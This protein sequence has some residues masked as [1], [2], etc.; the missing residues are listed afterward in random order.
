[1]PA[2]ERDERGGHRPEAMEHAGRAVIFSGS[3]VA[4]SLLALVVLPVPFLRSLGFAGLL[5]P[6]VSVAVA[7]TLLPVVLATIGPRLDRLRQPARRTSAG[8]GWSAWARLH[9][10]APLVVARSVDRHPPRAVLRRLHDPA[11]QPACRAAF[12]GGTGAR[13]ARPAGRTPASEPAPL[14]RSTRSS[15]GRPGRRRP[16]RSPRSRASGV[17]PSAADWRRDDTAVITLFPTGDG[18][19][20]AGRAALDR[21]ERGR[22]R[23]PRRRRD[24][25]RGRAVRRLHRRRLRQ[26]PLL[27]VLISVLIVRPARAGVPLAPAPPEG[28][29]VQPPLRRRP[30]GASW[31][32]SGSTASA[33][34]P[35]LR[36]RARPGR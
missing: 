18:N 22:G 35:S 26:L 11:R 8:R 2:A 24:R 4:I 1:M 3:T 9:R 14:A 25:R 28:R 36:H 6:L 17:P 7:V 34:R 23:P 33:R 21:S 30:P 32:S 27:V 12:T 19:S 5:I 29:P 13:R 10:P 31:W 16:Q 20:P 15:R